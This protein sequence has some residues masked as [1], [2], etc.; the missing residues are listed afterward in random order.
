MSTIYSYHQRYQEFPRVM[1]HESH[2][3]Y[4]GAIR[5]DLGADS[6]SDHLSAHN[7]DP[8]DLERLRSFR[9]IDDDFMTKVFEDRTCAE[10]LLRIILNRNDLIVLQVAVQR[11]IKNLQ[12]RSICLDIYA[13]DT[14]GRMYNI[15]VQRSDKGAGC[16]R[17]RYNSSLI[18]ADITE[19]GDRYEELAETYV[20]FI[21]E[22]DVIGKGLP[23]YHIERMIQETGE[24]FDDK[25]HIIYVNSQ[26]QDN[27]AL[28]RLM[29]DFW[30]TEATDMHYRVLADRVHHFK[31]EEEGIHNMCKAIEDMRNEAAR[32]ADHARKIMTARK[33]IASSRFNH[34]EIA[35]Y[36]ELPLAEVNELAAQLTQQIHV[37]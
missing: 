27:T 25:S 4:N 28:G 17:A 18:D 21:T 19:P 33:M 29:S 3:C 7:I 23:I 30:C 14:T 6:S 15:E 37:V 36:N 24:I 32:E 10:L 12:G 22:N 20:I 26:V 1:L 34:E 2:E 11:G 31:N 35:E 16:K 9:L 13:K 8:R 5:E